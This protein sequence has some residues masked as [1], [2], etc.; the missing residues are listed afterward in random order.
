ME[1]SLTKERL[2]SL[3]QRLNKWQ[4]WLDIENKKARIIEIETQFLDPN[5][6]QDREKAEIFS[7][8]LGK[9]KTLLKELEDKQK[10]LDELE[11][12]L[13]IADKEN[14]E[15]EALA[16]IQPPLEKLEKEM[17]KE[18]LKMFLSG[19]YDAGKASL[20]VYAGAGGE[21]AQDWARMLWEMYQNYA[22]ARGWEFIIL[23]EHKNEQGGIKSAVAEIVGDYAYG[24]LKGENGVHR[25][26]RISPFDAD[27]QRHTSFALVE[28]LPE[29][30]EKEYQL[31]EDDL[32]I[33]L[34]R[35][36]GPGGQNVNKVETAVRIKHKPTGI[37]V[38]CQSERSQDR[39]K[40]KALGLL[41][42]K[43]YQLAE[44]EARTEKAEIKGEKKQI[45]WAN[46]I[47]SYVLHPYQL[48]K[49]H[50]TEAETTQVEKVL[51]GDLDRFIEAE[52]K[53]KYNK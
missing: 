9:L 17:D 6:W 42:A 12:F 34:F 27:N 25:L 20:A 1:L 53:M 38:S 49:D 22:R 46:Q 8:E 51:A 16:E 13:F 29:I 24:Y 19:R 28:V 39:N 44:T 21:D 18:E 32:E 43:L 35:S 11:M 41:R 26:V 10:E 23:D 14:K 47:R 37:I 15:A 31:K 4:E 52:L 40:Q 36:S 48:V 33:D 50:R 3:R 45:A 2:Q 5:F 7:K 30:E